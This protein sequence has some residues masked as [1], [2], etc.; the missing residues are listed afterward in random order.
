MTKS[1]IDVN[2]TPGLEGRLAPG[3]AGRVASV[4]TGVVLILIE[5]NKSTLKPAGT[6]VLIDTNLVL[7]CGHVIADARQV[8]LQTIEGPGANDDGR[9]KVQFNVA[10]SAATAAKKKHTD[11]DLEKKRPIYKVTKV[12]ELQDNNAAAGT[13]DYALVRINR[14][15]D[16]PV[17]DGAIPQP[18]E[19][20]AVN[21]SP[22]FPGASSVLYTSNFS[23]DL[24]TVGHPSG[25]PMKATI[26]PT[27]LFNQGK[28]K[29]TTNGPL[30]FVDML[31][32]RG[33]SG[34]PIFDKA[35]K[36]CAI[37]LGD[38]YKDVPAGGE[39]HLTRVMPLDR[40]FRQSP[41]IR[42]M[43]RGLV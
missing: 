16:E 4:K 40:I 8:L 42:A 27:V 21:D 13:D 32:A 17:N 30:H 5:D 19:P 20:N 10:F 38:A 7:T 37:L 28:D 35:L 18:M 1:L 29:A 31:S 22:P 41:I 36:I 6:G 11:A 25:Q 43:L 14:P 34:S 12:E 2:D 33:A 9:I 26:G 23:G 39:K 24:L 15:T 3:S